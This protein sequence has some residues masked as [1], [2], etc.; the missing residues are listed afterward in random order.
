MIV[1][2]PSLKKQTSQD[3]RDLLIPMCKVYRS[4]HGSQQLMKRRL[5][6]YTTLNWL[7]SYCI[8]LCSHI[9]SY[10]FHFWTSLSSPPF[11]GLVVFALTDEG[12][13]NPSRCFTFLSPK[14]ELFR[15]FHFI[16]VFCSSQHRPQCSPTN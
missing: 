16:S 1:F 8:D 3:S 13:I 10:Y 6:Q 9:T 7:L 12:Q 2:M 14:G 4:V 11:K 15:M 5:A